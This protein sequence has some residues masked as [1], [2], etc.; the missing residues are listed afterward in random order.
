MHK[1]TRC[2]PLKTTRQNKTTTKILNVYK[3]CQTNRNVC[4][5]IQP[6]YHGSC[7]LGSRIRSDCSL[8]I[9]Q[10]WPVRTLIRETRN[11]STISIIKYCSITMQKDITGIIVQT[12][13]KYQYIQSSNISSIKI[14]AGILKLDHNNQYII[15]SY[16]ESLQFNI[17]RSSLRNFRFDSLCIFLGTCN[18]IQWFLFITNLDINTK[19]AICNISILQSLYPL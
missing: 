13:D 17:K 8:V 19:M 5:K 2:A 6:Y 14:L 4:L 7:S 11:L 18:S 9:W 1:S 15:T 10:G 12:N 16:I 3:A